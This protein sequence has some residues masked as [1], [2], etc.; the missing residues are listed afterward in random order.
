METVLSVSPAEGIQHANRGELHPP[1]RS[2]P[3]QFSELLLLL[4]GVAV[5]VSVPCRNHCCVGPQLCLRELWA[6]QDRALTHAP[7]T[8]PGKLKVILSNSS[9][10]SRSAGVAQRALLCLPSSMALQI[11]HCVR[12]LLFAQLPS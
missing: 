5:G 1:E 4:R 8:S 2:S 12:S 11:S 9:S 6:G 7:R 10:L 3:C